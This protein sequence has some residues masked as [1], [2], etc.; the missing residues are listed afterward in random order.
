MTEVER[1]KTDLEKLK[2]D[3]KARLDSYPIINKKNFKR[4]FK[5]ILT[6]ISRDEEKVKLLRDIKNILYVGL[7]IV[8]CLVIF[9]IVLM[10]FTEPI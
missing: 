5:E 2:V 6:E 9:T 4:V 3:T 10:L 7:T 1:V 8:V